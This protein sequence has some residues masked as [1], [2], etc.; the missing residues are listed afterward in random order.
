MKKRLHLAILLALS[1]LHA[2]LGQGTF[3]NPFN[4]SGGGT[5]TLFSVVHCGM[6]SCDPPTN[7]AVGEENTATEGPFVTPIP[8][9]ASYGTAPGNW[10]AEGANGLSYQSDASEIRGSILL[11]LITTNRQDI[12]VEWTV[13]DITTDANTNYVELQY[14]IGGVGNFVD[15]SGDLYESGNTPS[16]TVFNLTLPAVAN[17]E[18]LVQIRWIYYEIGSGTTDRLAVDDVTVSSS[19]LPVELLRFDA[20]AQRDE[21]R[22]EW[23]TATETRNAQFVVERSADGR[24]FSALHALAGAGDSREPLDYATTDAAPLRGQSFYRLKQVDFDGAFEYSPVRAVFM[25]SENALRLSPTW[26]DDA[27]TASLPEARSDDATWAVF[28]LQ[29]RPLRSGI[30]PAETPALP[31]SVGD[32]PAGGYVFSARGAAQRFFKK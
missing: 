30:W 3:P 5:F 27:L 8:S 26:A 31:L 10:Y 12:A 21:V 11:N 28:D 19:P 23:E 9:D 32:L 20:Y 14:R 29:G 25:G 16:G 15:L 6:P 13:R 7:I 17:N 4:M 22:L 24:N 18:A 2:L 1:T